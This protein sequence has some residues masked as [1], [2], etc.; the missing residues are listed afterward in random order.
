VGTFGDYVQLLAKGTTDYGL[1]ITGFLGYLRVPD[2]NYDNMWNPRTEEDRIIYSDES[3]TFPIG[4]FK[5]GSPWT[6]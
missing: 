4:R 6:Y 5:G 2:S 3:L 1:K